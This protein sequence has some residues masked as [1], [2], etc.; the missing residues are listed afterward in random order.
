MWTRQACRL[1]RETNR[2][3]VVGNVSV[4][5]SKAFM[6]LSLAEGGG[7]GSVRIASRDL[8]DEARG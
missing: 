1:V 5:F 7:P 8:G 6:A 4:S 2:C 3:G